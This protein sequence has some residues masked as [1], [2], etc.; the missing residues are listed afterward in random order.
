MR[1]KRHLVAV[2][3]RLQTNLSPDALALKSDFK[4]SILTIHNVNIK[5]RLM[6]ALSRIHAALST[7]GQQGEQQ[8]VDSCQNK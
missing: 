3:N 8:H 5:I 7:G 1:S 4:V 6:G 2:P